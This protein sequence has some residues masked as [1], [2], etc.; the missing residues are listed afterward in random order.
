MAILRPVI[1]YK[2]NSYEKSVR[3]LF[4]NQLYTD[5]E[6][7]PGQR[8]L[9]QNKAGHGPALRFVKLLITFFYR[10]EKAKTASSCLDPQHPETRN[11]VVQR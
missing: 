1:F 3:L 11:V 8:K 7:E 6:D 4:K 2:R 10:P 5:H 9:I